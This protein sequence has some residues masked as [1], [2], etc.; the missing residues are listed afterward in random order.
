MKII[1]IQNILSEQNVK[2][3]KR[4]IIN[5]GILIYPTDTLYGL[6]GNFFSSIVM[7][8]IDI[9][10]NRHDMPYSVIVPGLDMLDDLVDNIPQAFRT[11][12]QELLP[13][14]F[15]FLFKVSQSIDPVLVK[16][17][18]KIGIRI[19]NFPI[20]LKL[21]E[22]LGFPLISTSVN[23][24]GEPPLN[25]PDAIIKHFSSPGLNKFPLLLLDAGP[26]PDSKGSTILDITQTPAKCIR[27]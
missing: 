23:R 2:I 3:I 7:E 22:V 15:T 1:K 10:K 14:K 4:F 8:K 17:S 6:G 19:P 16:G 13:G 21:V 25:D 20:I 18:D 26:L 12:Y 9:L 27:K 11:M 5:H 24:S